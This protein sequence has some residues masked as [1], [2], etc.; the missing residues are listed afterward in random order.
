MPPTTTYFPLTTSASISAAKAHCSS[1]PA[2]GRS[3]YALAIYPWKMHLATRPENELG[4]QQGGIATTTC[5]CICTMNM[6]NDKR[7]KNQKKIKNKAKSI[8]LYWKQKGESGRRPE[9]TKQRIS[10]HRGRSGSEK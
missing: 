8:R 9:P 7:G 1:R 2:R 10:D 5:I 4:S 6:Q 3:T